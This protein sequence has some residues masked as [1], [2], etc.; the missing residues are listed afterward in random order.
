VLPAGA[1]AGALERALERLAAP[2]RLVVEEDRVRLPGFVPILGLED[3]RIAARLR[4]DAMAA[5]LEPPTPREWSEELGVA[6]PRLRELLAYL[7][8]EGSLVRA[9]GDVYFDRGAV[10]ELRARVV[11]HFEGQ[12]GLDTP[13]YKKLIGTT[14]KWAVPL[15]ELFD[16][17]HLTARRGESRVLRRRPL[18]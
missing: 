10:D 6:L 17:E 5:G 13:A 14:R 2:G 8:R 11:A 7:E 15:M 18:P 3:E 9:P 1:A 16:E 12:E 4:A